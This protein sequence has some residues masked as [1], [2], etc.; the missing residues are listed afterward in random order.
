[1]HMSVRIPG[2]SR[3]GPAEAEMVDHWLSETG[4]VHE[5]NVFAGEPP[6]E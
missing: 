6:L 3:R 5:P 1:M 2:L 4:G